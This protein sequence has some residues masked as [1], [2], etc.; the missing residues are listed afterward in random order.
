MIIW[1]GKGILTFFIIAI[2]MIAATFGYNAIDLENQRTIW[3]LMIPLVGSLLAAGLNYLMQRLFVKPIAVTDPQTG[4]ITT[5]HPK[6][7]LFF[8][9]VRYWTILLALGAVFSLI[10]FIY[11]VITK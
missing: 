11:G 2:S 10:G 4:V 9:P 1:R 8:I 3:G 7:S 5:H 6:D